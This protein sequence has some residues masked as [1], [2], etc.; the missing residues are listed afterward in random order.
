MI[1]GAEEKLK[2]GGEIASAL[3]SAF[4]VTTHKGRHIDKATGEATI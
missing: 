4:G 2:N 1:A 3:M